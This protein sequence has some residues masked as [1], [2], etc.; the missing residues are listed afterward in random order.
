MYQFRFRKSAA[1]GANQGGL[2]WITPA[3]LGDPDAG[4]AL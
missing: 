2:S 1:I 3:E 4:T